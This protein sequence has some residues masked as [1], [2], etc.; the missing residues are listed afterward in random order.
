MVDPLFHAIDQFEEDKQA[1][2][3]RKQHEHGKA[4]MYY[5]FLNADPYADVSKKNAHH[6]RDGADQIEKKI[7][8]KIACFVPSVLQIM[9]EERADPTHDQGRDNDQKRNDERVEKTGDHLF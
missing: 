5:T 7:D 2:A 3:Q 6:L 4:G 9:K 1:H 8:K